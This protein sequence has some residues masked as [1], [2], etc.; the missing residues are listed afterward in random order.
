[1]THD[2]P[3]PDALASGKALATLLES[4]WNIPSQLKYCGLVMR[5]ENK[6]LLNLLTPEWQHAD[7]ISDLD[8][9]SA[10][11]L[12]DTQPRAGNNR[13]PQDITPQVVID[14][15]HPLREKLDEVP[16]Q[17]VNPQIGSTATILTQYLQEAGVE[18]SPDLAT[19]MFYGIK[20][21]TRGLSRGTSQAD[22][23]VYLQ[24]LPIIDHKKLTQIEQ[25]GLPQVYFC[26]ISQGLQAAEVYDNSVVAY[27]GYMHRPDLPAE[28]ADILIRL[29]KARAILCLGLFE[30]NL[31]LSIRTTTF[32]QD[33]GLLVQQVIIQPGKAGGHGTMAGGQLPLDGHDENELVD[34]IIQRFLTVM[35]ETGNGQKLC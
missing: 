7:E 30:A 24:L 18:I 10:V 31:Y 1:M 29:D 34:Q 2:N 4:A 16:F 26:S 25:A 28:L 20:T 9:Y 15:H 5:A 17:I 6:A 21:D 12:V 35:G 32:S 27:L 19:A 8:Q 11:A 14:H 3:D 13:L 33:A 22:I 23:E